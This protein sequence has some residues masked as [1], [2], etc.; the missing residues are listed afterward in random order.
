LNQNRRCVSVTFAAGVD[1]GYRQSR[2]KPARFACRRERVRGLPQPL[3]WTTT[4]AE[5]VATSNELTTRC[6]RCVSR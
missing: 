3:Q 6:G 2:H 5:A 1:D 4:N